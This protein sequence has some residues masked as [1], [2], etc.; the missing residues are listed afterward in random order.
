MST[1]D[2]ER[3]A[4]QSVHAL[5]HQDPALYQLLEREHQRQQDV[6]WLVASSSISEPSVLSCGA[7]TIGN[8][9]TDGY[10]GRRYL[11]GCELADAIEVL[12]IERAKSLFRAVH[13]NV[14]PNS[15]TAA[16]QSILFKFLRAGDP[17][18]GM[19]LKAGGHLTHGSKA[20]LLGNY[21][22]PISYGVDSDGWIDYDAVRTIAQQA[23]PK[24]IIAGASAYSRAID[25]KQFRT[26]ADEIGAYLLADISH[27]SGLIAT[28]ELPSPIDDA[29][30]ITMSTYKQLWG[31]KGGLI[32]LGKDAASDVRHEH[33]G[34]ISGVDRG[35]SPFLQD[36]PNLASIAAK[37]RAL[38]FVASD[39]FK[40]I[41]KRIKW[42]AK[43]MA[44][45]LVSRGYSLL[46]GG[47]DNHIVFIDLRPKQI[48]G[49]V[50]ERAL[51]ECNI[52]ANRNQI[53]NDPLP[54]HIASGLRFGTNIIAA[55][56]LS[57]EAILRSVD[58]I[59]KVLSSV[60]MFGE[61]R[62][63]LPDAVKSQARRD[64]A[65]LCRSFPIPGY[66]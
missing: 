13:A 37:A 53:P 20:S 55:R 22:K 65:D 29:H 43:L 49:V 47:T 57:A 19:D 40:E 61:S 66:L 62:Y 52:I 28:G 42:S 34:L 10:P 45:Q 6:L 46:T 21:F 23:R 54:P 8:V 17:F 14:Q 58:V 7:M 60:E 50:A 64:I 63:R 18:M 36:T 9:T 16:N 51:E 5:Q 35:V 59:D 44:T 48:T 41:A 3:F 30:F 15:G 11:P 4:R 26:I 2:L 39:G 33:G 56:G 32:L 12:A 38:A 25:Y 24:L 31:P 27:I 1:V